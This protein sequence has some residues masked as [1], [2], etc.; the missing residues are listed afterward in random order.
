MTDLQ[1]SLPRLTA[2]EE[3]QY[4]TSEQSAEMAALRAA[5]ISE[6]TKRAER[7]SAMIGDS[8]YER[9]EADFYPT[10]PEN[11]DCL[12]QHIIPHSSPSLIWEPACGDGAIS[13]RLM[14]FGYETWSSDLFDHGFGTPNMD[15]LAQTKL[16]NPNIRAIFTNPP[17]ETISLIE[18]QWAYL[19][20]LA[21][22]Y[23]IRSNKVSLAELF[24]RHAIELMRPVKGQVAMFLRNEFDCGSKRMDLFSLP[25]FH[26][27]IVVT[28]RPRWIADST[29]SPRHNYSWFVFDWRHISGAAGVSYSHPDLAPGPVKQ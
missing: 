26:K 1:T 9:I 2:E 25:P 23:G 10:P 29:G 15:F 13:E 19:V 21:R 20:P 6:G 7:D 14:E 4:Y 17:Y 12:L 5:S 22:K 24:L 11:V 16:P 27:K 28:K 18:E 3:E 8:G